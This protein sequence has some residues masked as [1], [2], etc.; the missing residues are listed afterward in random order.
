ME[1]VPDAAHLFE[2][3]Q[4]ANRVADHHR[5]L[6][7]IQHALDGQA[8]LHADAARLEADD[9]QVAVAPH[10]RRGDHHLAR[11]CRQVN[12]IQVLAPAAEPA[13]RHAQDALIVAPPRFEL[14][15]NR[16]RAVGSGRPA[17]QRRR[18]NLHGRL[19]PRA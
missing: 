8:R 18:L 2:H 1:R 11:A 7:H 15:S 12:R 6:I 14:H 16:E 9:R 5:Q 4:P 17:Q 19:P 3:L 13:D 10:N